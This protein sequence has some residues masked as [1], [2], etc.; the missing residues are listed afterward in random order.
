MRGPSVQVLTHAR[1]AQHV[2]THWFPPTTLEE[3]CLAFARDDTFHSLRPSSAVSDSQDDRRKKKFIPGP[4]RHS[5]AVTWEKIVW[6]KPE[7]GTGLVEE[8]L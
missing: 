3:S 4:S 7:G 6:V 1:K 2:V 8:A 5:L